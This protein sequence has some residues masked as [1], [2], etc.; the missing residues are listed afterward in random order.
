MITVV[1][2]VSIVL[3]RMPS[4]SHFYVTHFFTNDIPHFVFVSRFL[5]TFPLG[6]RFVPL[7]KGLFHSSKKKGSVESRKIRILNVRLPT[8]VFLVSYRPGYIDLHQ[9]RLPY[10]P[11][12]SLHYPNLS[13]STFSTFRNLQPYF[14]NLKYEIRLPLLDFV[15]RL[16]ESKHKSFIVSSTLTFLS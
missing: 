14:S 2:V 16:Y 1:G 9:P 5:R 12:P 15:P 6:L 10:T 4:T 8:S 13:S 3:F 7:P 11:T